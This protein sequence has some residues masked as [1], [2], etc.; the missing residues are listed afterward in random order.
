MHKRV[1]QV[2][3]VIALHPDHIRA[4]CAACLGLQLLA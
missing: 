4:Q 1:L 3:A 2:V